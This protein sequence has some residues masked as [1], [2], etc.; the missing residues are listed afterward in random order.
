MWISLS[1][2]NPKIC[3]KVRV[4]ESLNQIILANLWKLNL[5]LINFVVCFWLLQQWMF[6]TVP[7]LSLGLHV[8]IHWVGLTKTL[9]CKILPNYK[10]CVLEVFHVKIYGITY[11]EYESENYRLPLWL[12]LAW[13]AEWCSF[14]RCQNHRK[15]PSRKLILQIIQNVIFIHTCKQG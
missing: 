13:S 11:F 8:H 5:I 1:T 10:I 14:V 15:T 7:H 2:L 6:D 9:K 4:E 12:C 3:G